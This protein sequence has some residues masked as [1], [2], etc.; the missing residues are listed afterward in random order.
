MA[1]TDTD[2]ITE[3]DYFMARLAAARVAAM[4]IV[5]AIDEATGYC[6]HPDEDKSGKKREELVEAALEAAGDASRALEAAEASFEDVDPEEGEPEDE[7]EDEPEEEEEPAP[8]TTR[9]R[10]K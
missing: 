10:R 4:D 7:E 2:D 6:V 9:K 5:T 8:R 3:R 1:D